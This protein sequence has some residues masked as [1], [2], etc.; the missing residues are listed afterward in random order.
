MKT[1]FNESMEK[2][3]NLLNLRFRRMSLKGSE[4]T[5]YEGVDA[6]GVDSFFEYLHV[7]DATPQQDALRSSD[8]K[9]CFKFQEF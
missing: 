1:E 8:L 4:L 9:K 7:V 2:V 3:V 6:S 5:T